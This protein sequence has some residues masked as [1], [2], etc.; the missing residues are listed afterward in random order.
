MSSQEDSPASLSV[1]LGSEEARMMT[2][3][4]GRTCSALSK[5]AG[6]LGSLVKML[7]A[8]PVWH[9][10]RVMLEWTYAPLLKAKKHTEIWRRQECSTA[11]VATSNER[12]MMSNRLLFR[13]VPQT[14]RTDATASGSS[15]TMLPTITSGADRNTDYA[16]GGKCLKTGLLD[17]GLLPTPNAMNRDRTDVA[18]NQALEGKLLTA[19]RNKAGTQR[20][21]SIKDT[22]MYRVVRQNMAEGLLPT[23]RVGG[24]EGYETR[25]A[26]Q[27]HE[28]AV[29]YL[30]AAVE[31]QMSTA[32][33]PTP[34]ACEAYKLTGHESQD[35]LTKRAREAT[36]K[37]SQLNPLF[38]E[39]MMGFPT[40]WTLMPF[41]KG[42]KEASAPPQPP[43]TTGGTKP[44]KPTATP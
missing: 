42:R 29:S 21:F 20:H 8:S 37:T 39:E 36:G 41:L 1:R 30:E 10:H 15:A 25:K 38:V 13:L 33:L 44:S 16:Q 34:Q 24:Q 9:S 14:P 19:R 31:W 27:G 28:K 17:A 7:L 26:R 18:I 22:I 2:A 11:F 3:T 35:S 12:D 5:S 43:T 6:P 32:M 23:P 40:Y 4:S